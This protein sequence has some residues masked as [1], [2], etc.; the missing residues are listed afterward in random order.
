MTT[1]NTPTPEPKTEDQSTAAVS[2]TRL[3]GIARDEEKADRHGLATGPPVEGMFGDED[4]S[5]WDAYNNV[6]FA[7]DPTAYGNQ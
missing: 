2:S 5:F 1:E 4:E 3:L 7:G 6:A